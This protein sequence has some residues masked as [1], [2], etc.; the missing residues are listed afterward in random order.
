MPRR[1][2]CLLNTHG[3]DRINCRWDCP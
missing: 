2:F 3:N 1:R